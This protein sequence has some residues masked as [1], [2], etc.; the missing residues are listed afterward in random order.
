[1]GQRVMEAPIEMV[2]ISHATCRERR[3]SILKGKSQRTSE[4]F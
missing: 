2:G 4:D 3:A 1:M